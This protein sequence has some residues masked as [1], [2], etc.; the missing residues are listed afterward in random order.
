[1]L[2]SV[3]NEQNAQA[4]AQAEQSEE[5]ASVSV[6]EDYSRFQ[7]GAEDAEQSASANDA[8]ANVAD[9]AGDYTAAFEPGSV[10]EKVANGEFNK[11]E[12][13]VEVDGFTSDDARRSDDFAEQFQ[14]ARHPELLPFL[15]MNPS[16]YDDLFAWLAAQ[17]N[18]DIDEALSKN[19]GY[20]DYRNAMGK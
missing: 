5:S 20:E 16:L 2:E 14:M 11:Q 8:D 12:P 1:M 4:A 18:A 3:D 19:A 13:L 10:F 15:A 17:G 7:R 6:D 9:E